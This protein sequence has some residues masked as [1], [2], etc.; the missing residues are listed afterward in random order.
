MIEID[1]VMHVDGK[2]YR[3][4]RGRIIG[5]GG[6]TTTKRLKAFG[7]LYQELLKVGTS[8]ELRGFANLY[9][10]LTPDRAQDNKVIEG[11]DVRRVLGDIEIMRHFLKTLKE[12]N[13]RSG[14]LPRWEGGQFEVSLNTPK[15]AA[16]AP[17]IAKIK[18]AA[19]PLPFS[20]KLSAFLAPNPDTGEWEFHLRPL[21]LLDALWLQ[22]GQGLVS[23]AELRS[24]KQCGKWFQAGAGGK[25]RADAK[26]CSPECRR[27]Y[28]SL[29]RSL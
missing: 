1:F 24:C 15:I 16:A 13:V 11:D 23:K 6:A 17:A 20:G 25:V 21:S 22:F 26:F 7:L 9:G 4:D 12:G 29:K 3:L 8:E 19:I 28:N 14:E 2:G 10:R 27:K 5:N 18:M